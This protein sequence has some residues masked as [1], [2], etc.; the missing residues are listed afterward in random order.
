MPVEDASHAT[1]RSNHD[2]A[3]YENSSGA[4]AEMTRNSCATDRHSEKLRRPAA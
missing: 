4:S 3:V 2:A 1:T